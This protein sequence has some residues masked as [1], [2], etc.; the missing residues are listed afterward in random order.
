MEHLNGINQ[1][2]VKSSSP[3]IEVVRAIIFKQGE[4]L[5][6][7]RGE[8]PEYGRWCLPGGKVDGHESLEAAVR[9]E[10]SEEVGLDFSPHY[11]SLSCDRYFLQSELSGNDIFYATYYFRGVGFGMPRADGKE[12]SRLR[13]FSIPKILERQDL[14]FYNNGEG[15]RNV[16]HRIKDGRLLASHSNVYK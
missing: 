13:W 4:V 7:E 10:V 3:E 12:V 5:L 14:A 11:F 6:V 9:R 2:A 8:S 15:L 1:A 16:L